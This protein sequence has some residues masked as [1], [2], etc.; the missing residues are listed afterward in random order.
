MGRRLHPCTTCGWPVID[1][2]CQPK[3]WVWPKG[4]MSDEEARRVVVKVPVWCSGRLDDLLGRHWSD[5]TGRLHVFPEDLIVKNAAERY[6]E[7]MGTPGCC[8]VDS[9][10]GRHR[11]ALR[12]RNW[13]TGEY[14]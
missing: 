2:V 1:G 14:L 5:G 13:K 6:L 12:G 11:G 9:P 3:R 4:L 10:C 7:A 8:T